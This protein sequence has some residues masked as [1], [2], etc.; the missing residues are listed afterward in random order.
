MALCVVRLTPPSALALRAPR[1]AVE[2]SREPVAGESV[3]GPASPKTG[4]ATAAAAWLG[5]GVRVRVRG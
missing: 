2:R 1:V 4:D 5:L 3:A